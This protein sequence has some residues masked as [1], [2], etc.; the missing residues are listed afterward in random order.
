M[1]DRR[2]LGGGHASMPP[3][4]HRPAPGTLCACS[5]DSLTRCLAPPSLP[6]S[7]KLTLHL[8][9]SE[10]ALK[11]TLLSDCVMDGWTHCILALLLTL[12]R[13]QRA[14]T[15]SP[16]RPSDFEKARHTEETPTGN[17]NSEDRVRGWLAS[18][19]KEPTGSLAHFF[20]GIEGCSLFVR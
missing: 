16:M 6:F 1:T 12:A 18:A 13:P 7:L 8:A 3:N 14:R 4:P 11:L 17:R 19:C 2:F 5:R 9:V 10:H 15:A 20:R